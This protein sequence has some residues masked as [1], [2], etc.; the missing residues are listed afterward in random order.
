MKHDVT[1]ASRP[2]GSQVSDEVICS[3]WGYRTHSWLQWCD[4]ETKRKEVT[5]IY[6]WTWPPNVRLQGFS[7]KPGSWG[8]RL[9]LCGVHWCPCSLSCD[10]HQGRSNNQTN[11]GDSYMLKQIEAL[12]KPVTHFCQHCTFHIHSCLKLR[13]SHSLYYSKSC[14]WSVLIIN[15]T[16]CVRL[17][18]H[19][20]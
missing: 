14:L 1:H 2:M 3:R 11:D 6:V 12:R 16:P 18:T 13:D 7:I 4:A 19:L 10:P 17:H 9:H 15:L 20:S 5:S 8:R